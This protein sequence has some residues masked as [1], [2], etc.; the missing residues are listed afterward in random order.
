MKQPTMYSKEWSDDQVGNFMLAARNILN[1]LP[2][3]FTVSHQYTKGREDTPQRFAKMLMEM[4][5]GELYTNDEIVE[6][7]K[8]KVFTEKTYLSTDCEF[9]SI[10]CFSF[11]EHHLALM[12]DINIDIKI[13]YSPDNDNHVK[14][15][16]LS[17]IPRICDLVCK[18]LQL[19]E[20]IT[21]DVHYIISSLLNVP[22]EVV[23]RGKHSCV[24]ARGIKK[25][26]VFTSKQTT[27]F[28][29][30]TV[31]IENGIAILKQ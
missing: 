1:A 8:D 19:Q 29:L 24:S 25:D 10:K 27:P 14:V 23:V 12:Y 7:F 28:K 4:L 6:L 9:E 17:K 3:S 22:I 18:R 26:I 16:G 31:D 15:V 5:E 11:C 20:R 30:P 13:L 2:S 21:S